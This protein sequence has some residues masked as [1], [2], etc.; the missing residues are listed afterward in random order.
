MKYDLIIIGGG[1][2]GLTAASQARVLNRTVALIEKEPNLGGDCLHYGC[3]P[4]KS[5]IH[6]SKEV[7]QMRKHMRND[8]IQLGVD[9]LVESAFSKVHADIQHILTYHD[10]KEI[11]RN[12][13]V[14]VYEGFGSIVDRNHVKVMGKDNAV[15]EGDVIIIASGSRPIVPNIPGIENSNFATNETIF[16]R[17]HVPKTMVVIGGGPIGLELGQAF[18]HLGAKVTLIEAQSNILP[19]EDDMLAAQVKRYL[20]NDMT[21]LIDTRVLS[22]DTQNNTQKLKISGQHGTSEVETELIFLAVGRKANIELLNLDGCGI[23]HHHGKIQTDTRMRT[24]KDN[25]YAVGDVNFNLAFT[26]TANVEAKIAIEDAFGTHDFYGEYDPENIPYMVFTTPQV[27]RNGLSK[28]KAVEK[29]GEAAKVIRVDLAH[30]DRFIVDDKADGFVE[31]ILNGEGK[32]LG[33]SA[34]GEDI[35]EYLQELSFAKAH[36]MDI[37]SVM[38]AIHPYPGYAEVCKAVSHHALSATY[39]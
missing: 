29:Y 12:K 22:V 36:G 3:V 25:I 32:I 23:E 38:K 27:Y 4:S 16:Y 19:N 18:S 9:M 31:V 7:R 26:H 34:V 35:G 2:G 6:A 20:E 30:I 10:S 8:H 13:G 15:L 21:I 17:K 14:D 28:R 5:L 11:Y 37:A 24:N 39:K 1:A 33:I